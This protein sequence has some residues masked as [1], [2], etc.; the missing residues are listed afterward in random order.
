MKYGTQ[1]IR[2]MSQSQTV[3]SIFMRTSLRE[4]FYTLAE[5]TG[6]DKYID[7]YCS[8]IPLTVLNENYLYDIDLYY[9]YCCELEDLEESGDYAN[10][11]FNENITVGEMLKAACEMLNHQH[12]SRLYE[13]DK[14][15]KYDGILEKQGRRLI[16]E[17][18]IKPMLDMEE[19]A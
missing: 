4:Y 17:I 7:T 11:S 16:E 18:M 15:N 3:Q 8:I 13:D 6:N 10:S 19:F 1:K 2:L 9:A 5:V 12:C 14:P